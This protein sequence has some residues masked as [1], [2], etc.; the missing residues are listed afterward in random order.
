MT[1]IKVHFFDSL[2]VKFLKVTLPIVVVVA[3]LLF[4]VIE[5]LAARRA[6]DAL[7]E[8][9]EDLV[10]NYS[11][12]S[13]DWV[14]NLDRDRIRVSLEHLV[15]E[16][17]VVG[18]LV[19]DDRGAEIA[20]AGV[21]GEGGNFLSASADIVFK[22]DSSSE[23]I[24]RVIFQ[25]SDETVMKQFLDQLLKDGILAFII[26]SATLIGAIYA[27]RRAV[28]TPLGHMMTSIDK[29]VGYD[30]PEPIDWQS[31]DEIGVVVKSFNHLM[32]RRR[33]AEQEKENIA[34][35]LREAQKLEA[36]G[37]LAGGI[38][39]EINT[40]SQYIG[41]NLKFLSDAHEDLFSLVE[42]CLVLTEAAGGRDGLSSLANDVN[43]LCDEIDLE[44]LREEIPSATKQS[45]AGIGQVSRIVL[46][47]KEFSHPGTKEKSLADINRALE[48]TI[49]ISRNEWKHVAELTS[50]LDDALPAV[51]CLA[52]EINQVFLNLIVNAAHAITEKQ[53]GSG[54]GQI[55][56]ST[57]TDGENVII[58][59]GDD[60]T[61][62]PEEVQDQI[63]NPFFTTKELGQGTGQGLAI[64]RDIVVKKH[65]G[66]IS[67]DTEAGKGTTFIVSLPIR[68]AE[69]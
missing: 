54:M 38:A 1:R 43:A 32:V 65:G 27:N 52:G 58:R 24:G 35:E 14:W 46:A 29:T 18:A 44:Y 60:G 7:N 22:T 49:T 21:T 36:V 2:E 30:L 11:I 57:R 55:K 6:L 63:F 45:I 9:K 19:V 41:D 16:G 64:S 53:N 3:A 62:I 10:Q 23:K 51:S 17:I 31:N 15:K 8:K 50:T 68:G 39:H 20:S 33:Q 42:K 37:Q 25:V 66:T 5:G 56:V 59:I 28:T 61:G 34:G 12:L 69:A 4:G 48:N 40:P 13:S 26:L 67:F 47:M